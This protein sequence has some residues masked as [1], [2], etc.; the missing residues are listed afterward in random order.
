MANVP[1]S[2]DGVQLHVRLLPGGYFGEHI[3]PGLKP[4]DPIELE[5]PFGD[6]YLRDDLPPDVI[7]LAGGTGFAPIQS[8]LEEVLPKRTGHSFHLFWGARTREGLYALD[9]IKKWQTKYQHFKFVGV[10]SDDSHECDF[11]H[12]MV[13]HAV[14]DDFDSLARTHVYACGSPMMITAAR[15]MFIRERMLPAAN[16]FS[17]AFVSTTS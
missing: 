11:R 15:H 3:L 17:D 4:G 16:F 9:H 7:L 1:R 6:F 13:H 5:L 12:G 8:M 10:V 14:A 2:S